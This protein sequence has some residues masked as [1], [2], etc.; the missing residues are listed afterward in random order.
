MVTGDL[1]YANLTCP[2]I[3]VSKKSWFVFNFYDKYLHLRC[4]CYPVVNICIKDLPVNTLN[5]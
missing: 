1:L 4:L 3:Y 5:T 2:S